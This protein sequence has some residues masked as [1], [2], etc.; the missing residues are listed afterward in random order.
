MNTAPRPL[1]TLQR[2]MQSVI[3][4]PL[5]IVAGIESDAAR[6]EIAVSVADIENVIEPSKACSSIERLGV[7]GNAYFARLLECMRELFPATVCAVGEEAFDQFTLE[8]LQ[9]YPP[10]SYTLE[11]LSDQFVDFL[12][13]TRP[14]DEG[15][16]GDLGGSWTEFVVDL[17]RLEWTIDKVFDG[18]GV[19]NSPRLSSEQ[20]QAIPPAEWPHARI[21]VASCLRLLE[22][23]FPVNDYYTEFR[24]GNK[25]DYPAAAE[26][27]AAISRRDYVVRRFDLSSPQFAL[28]AALS[29]GE[30]IEAAIAAAAEAFFAAGGDEEQLAASLPRW[31]QAWTA[32]G[33]FVKV[34]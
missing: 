34:A 28:L 6:S 18:P 8:Y 2:W 10:H 3:M 19:E 12:E 7:Y 25:P 14:A 22:F 32:E 1:D 23:R 30:T 16:F 27:F 20:L 29:A 15:E 33:F 4:H 9:A 13:E 26:S 5:G 21:E 31:F 17:A 11:H 24:Q